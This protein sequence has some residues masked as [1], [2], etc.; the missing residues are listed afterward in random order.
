MD[1]H[2][3][4][5]DSTNLWLKQRAAQAEQPTL[6]DGS[7]PS[8]SLSKA[9][10]TDHSPIENFSIVR[11]DFQ[12]AG[13]GQ[14][15]NGW[16]SAAGDNLLMSMLF[17]PKKMKAQNQFH[18][19]EMASLAV[20][21]VVGN[22]LPDDTVVEV[23]WPND[24]Y[25]NERKVCGMLIENVL[26]QEGMIRQSVIGIGLNLN[27]TE[28]SSDAPNPASLIQFMPEGT[29][30]FSAAEIAKL[31]RNEFK[32]LYAG[33]ISSGRQSVHRMYLESLRGRDEY[34]RYAVLQPS[35]APAP[36][37]IRTGKNPTNSDS[38]ETAPLEEI[39]AIIEDVAS[40]G[41]LDL[42]LRDGDRR[43]F[44]FKEI[45]PILPDKEV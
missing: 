5:L 22:L 18:I 4:E 24:I 32:E 23:K 31:I 9:F 13:R 16:E 35:T 20:W 33:Y 7:N 29:G 38:N 28:F 40:D 34:K 2:F 14:R 10:P 37:A 12:T 36:T 21:M 26:D 41:R 6:C 27:Q 30:R 15:G 1:F 39:E 17:L 19:S 44:Y 43:S 8:R 42:L 11:A 3:D 45:T 25:V